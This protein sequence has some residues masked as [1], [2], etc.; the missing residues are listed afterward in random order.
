MYYRRRPTI[1]G[2]IWRFIKKLIV[3]VIRLISFLFLVSFVLSFIA[4]FGGYFA[5]NKEP[6][7]KPNTVLTLNLS[8]MIIDG[9]GMDPTLQM[10]LRERTQTL[11]E[12]T[13]NIRKA[14]HD[15]RIVGILLK[16]NGVGMSFTTALDIRE[17]LL[18]FKQS[19]KK[20]YA[21]T[22]D[23]GLGSYLVLSTADKIYMPPSG[24]AFVMGLRAEIPFYKGLF[25]KLG[26]TPEFVAIGKYKTGPQNFT[27]DHLSDEYREVMD[28]LLDAYYTTYVQKI[29]EA[30]NVPLVEVRAWIDDG[31]YSARDALEA[32]MVDELVYEPQLDSILLKELGL[33]TPALPESTPQTER[34]STPTPTVS[35]SEQKPEPTVIQKVEPSAPESTLKTVSMTQYTRAKVDA[36]NLHQQGEKIAVVYASGTIVSGRSPLSSGRFIASDTL[37]QLLSDLE[38]DETIRGVILRVDSGGGSALASDLIRSR[39]LDMTRKKPVIISMANAAASGGYMISAPANKI[40]AYPVTITGSIGIYGGKFSMRG[41]NDWLGVTVE[42]LQRGENA[43]LFTSA[44]T[45]TPSEHERFQQYIQ[46]GYENFVNIVAQGRN[47][48]FAMAADVAEGRVWT[49]EQAADIGL[50][51]SLGNL[52]TAIT[53]LKEQLQISVEQDVQMMVY[54]RPESPLE[55]LLQNMQEVMVNAAFPK[56]FLH[57]RARFETLTRLQDDRL[58][59]WW[60]QR[61]LFE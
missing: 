38:E 41:L 37:N 10:L 12:I 2:R 54:P 19:G 61:I 40:V 59:A 34:A 5:M 57:A 60:P 24:C 21:Y 47:M 18:A 14:A 55:M 56:E 36:P 7:I 50:V 11:Q 9:P 53:L 13:T 29:A 52:E 1:V 22:P 45:H 17:E 26:I 48:T 42:T 30:R 8:G 3:F 39:I 35:A 32:G 44:R 25:D 58:F 27:M 6:D 33:S 49:G 46:D 51:D 4:M 31:L 15:D 23:A 43:G 20:I 28:D 16:T